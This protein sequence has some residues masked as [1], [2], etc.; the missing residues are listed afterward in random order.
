MLVELYVSKLVLH[1][2]YL[3]IMCF[4]LKSIR[5]FSLL[6]LPFLKTEEIGFNTAI[7]T[8]C[9]LFSVYSLCY[10]SPNCRFDLWLNA[11][12]STP[13][14]SVGNIFNAL[15][16]AENS[17]HIFTP[18]LHFTLTKW[19]TCPFARSLAL[20]WKFNHS[21]L[22]LELWLLFGFANDSIFYGSRTMNNNASQPTIRSVLLPHS[23]QISFSLSLAHSHSHINSNDC[24]YI[25]F[26][27][28]FLNFIA[29]H[30]KV[31]LL[32]SS[33]H[34]FWICLSVC[35]NVWMY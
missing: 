35:M 14:H 27:D 13:F 20:Q 17:F 8:T 34:I 32:S 21:Q 24:K 10:F 11:Q 5:F 26:I 6:F 19:L 23:L 16:F 2:C 7:D 4:F 3:H 18:E 1:H 15:R 12:I 22:R 9:V 33:I 29:E 31:A 28:H 30:C 25:F